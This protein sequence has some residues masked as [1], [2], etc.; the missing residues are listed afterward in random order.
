[1][2][3]AVLKQDLSRILGL[4]VK[5]IERTAKGTVGRASGMDYNTTPPCGTVRIY[6]PRSNP[7]DVRA[8]Y[9]FVCLES[10]KPGKYNVTAMCLC[11]GNALNQDFDYYLQVTGK[12][13]KGTGLGTY[14]DGADR[15]RPMLIFAN[16]LGTKELDKAATLIHSSHLLE[17]AFP[18]L[19]LV[20]TLNRLAE[21]QQHQFFCYRL[22]QDVPGGHAQKAI[23]F[24]APKRTTETQQRPRFFLP[25]SMSG[26]PPPS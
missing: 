26:H 6:D 7:V 4:E 14:K 19:K 25:F 2:E 20:Y 15:Q 17:E 11:D 21:T 16:P 18:A 24:L 5:K 22:R 8:F 23:T 1:V 13:Q 3:R 12:R 9:L 10:P